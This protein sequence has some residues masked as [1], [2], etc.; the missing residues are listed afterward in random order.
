MADQ[1]ITES[2]GTAVVKAPIEFVD[3]STWLFNLR[4]ADY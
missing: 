1:L 3:I 2:S 4:D